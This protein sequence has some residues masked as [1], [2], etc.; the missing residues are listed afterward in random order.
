LL[1]QENWASSK[2]FLETSSKLVVANR[3]YAQ[4]GFKPFD[5]D[6]LAGGLIGPT[7]WICNRQAWLGLRPDLRKAVCVTL[8][9][10][11]RSKGRKGCA[12]PALDI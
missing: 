7:H 9:R 6:H 3:L 11:C 5:S 10:L 4:F 12:F 1:E 8:L 2:L